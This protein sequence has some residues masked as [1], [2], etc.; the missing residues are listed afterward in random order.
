MTIGLVIDVAPLDRAR[1]KAIARYGLRKF[2]EAHERQL[3][4]TMRQMRAY[5]TKNMVT[6]LKAKEARIRLRIKILRKYGEGRLWVTKGAARILASRYKKVKR[7]GGITLRGTRGV[8]F[9]IP[10]AFIAR[11][12]YTPQWV[13]TG[14]R[15][16]PKSE[17]SPID[18]ADEFIKHSRRAA[19]LASRTHVRRVFRRLRRG[20]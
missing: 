19:T 7:K 17:L 5:M 13:V 10:G 6:G 20:V 12:R 8:R 1:K 9:S 16:K 18:F 2:N 15:K 14:S 4:D 11:G 3:R